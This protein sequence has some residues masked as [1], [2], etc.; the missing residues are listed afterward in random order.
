ME[1]DLRARLSEVESF[2]GKIHSAI[3]EAYIFYPSA[4]S[5]IREGIR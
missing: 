4:P 2:C 3:E 1:G 5:E